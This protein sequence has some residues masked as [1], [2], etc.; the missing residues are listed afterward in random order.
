MKCRRKSM[1]EKQR[2]DLMNRN[3]FA[4][5]RRDNVNTGIITFKRLAPSLI[6][7]TVN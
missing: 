7:T 1:R 4:K 6:E 3:D 2:R 5:A